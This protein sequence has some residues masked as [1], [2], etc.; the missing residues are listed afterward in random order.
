[1]KK[2]T[3]TDQRIDKFL[4]SVRIYKTRS[5]ATEACKKGRVIIN[6]LPV[7]ASRLVIAGEIIKVKKT[8]VLYTY[9]IKGIPPSRVAAKIVDTYL[10]DHT[11]EEEKIKLDMKQKTQVLYRYRG[12]GR[13]TKKE[14][15]DLDRLMDK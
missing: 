9:R 15:R 11:P 6:E 1:M 5:M 4:W 13:P 10:E 7:K 14:R 3:E 8:P 2:V 12:R